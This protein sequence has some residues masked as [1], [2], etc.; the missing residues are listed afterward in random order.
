M[1][2]FRGR[3]SQADPG[4]G[5]ARSSL[6][7]GPRGRVGGEQWAWPGRYP[8]F[9]REPAHYFGYVY[10][11]QVKDSSVKRG[12][13]QKVSSWLLWGS[14]TESWGPAAIGRG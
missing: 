12:Y 4:L 13:F 5:R 2:A 14:P 1:P 6:R 8:S 3:D 11:R 7:G 10:F 9:Q